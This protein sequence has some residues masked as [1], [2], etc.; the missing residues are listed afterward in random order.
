MPGVF[1]LKGSAVVFPVLSAGRQ[2]LTARRISRMRKFSRSKT[3]AIVVEPWSSILSTL[4]F[5]GAKSEQIAATVQQ[6]CSTT[7]ISISGVA[8]EELRLRSNLLRPRRDLLQR[9]RK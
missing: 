4:R 9:R 5:G 3:G 7:P 8:V 2:T 1:E 6:I